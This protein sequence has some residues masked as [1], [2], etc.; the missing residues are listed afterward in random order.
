[1]LQSTLRAALVAAGTICLSAAASAAPNL[2]T[3]GSFESFGGG[4]FT[5]WT[6]GGNTGTTPPQYATPHPTNG[7]TP[8]QFGDVVPSAPSS[9]S[10]DAPGVQGAYFVADNA[11][12]SLSQTVSG[13]TLGASYEV[14]FSLFQ[15]ASGAANPGFFTLQGLY[16]AIV[17]T[18]ATGG[19]PSDV[20]VWRQYSAT[21]NAAST[22]DTF[23]FLFSSG[24]TPSKDV[25]ADLVYLTAAPVTAVPEPASM[26]LLGAGLL[27]LGL[28]RR[29]RG[30]R[31]A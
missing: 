28:V 14:G 21:F 31:A 18:T 25:I 22:T 11:T 4:V 12:Q 16:G 13:L 7:T 30:R 9:R 19:D 6:N 3:N 27:G 29:A 20:G 2:I 5:G 1:M 26:A 8:G 10:P 17:V 23:T 24:A 15:T